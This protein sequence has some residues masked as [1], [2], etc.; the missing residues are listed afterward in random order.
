MIAMLDHSEIDIEISSTG[1][2]TI[3]FNDYREISEDDE[4]T[5]S[6]LAMM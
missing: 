2:E 3:E 6:M 1:M 5:N 4:D